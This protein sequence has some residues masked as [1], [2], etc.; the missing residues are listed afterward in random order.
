MTS[1]SL[2]GISNLNATNSIFNIVGGNQT[3]VN[4]PTYVYP[5][6]QRPTSLAS[7]R[8]TVSGD[9]LT[10]YAF[11]VAEIQVSTPQSV[12]DAPVG[13]LSVHFT[14]GW[15]RCSI[16][17]ITAYQAAALSMECQE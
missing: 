5:P 12:N 16:G 6:G 8:V 14:N 7:R 4:H 9:L 17:H 3:T 2:Q 13:R 15:R 11:L 1:N 10:S